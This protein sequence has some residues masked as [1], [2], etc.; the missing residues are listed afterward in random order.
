MCR[1]AI[2]DCQRRHIYYP[3][4]FQSSCPD[5]ATWKD[6]PTRLDPCRSRTAPSDYLF[7][8]HFSE[9][10]NQK[11]VSLSIYTKT[12]FCI[13]RSELISHALVICMCN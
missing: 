8:L 1:L 10:K 2:N 7:R 11:H 12:Y 6:V 9:Q 5:R 3:L 13:P 4:N